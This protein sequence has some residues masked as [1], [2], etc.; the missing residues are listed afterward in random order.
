MREICKENILFLQKKASPHAITAQL[1][2]E[3]FVF[4]K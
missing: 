1:N 2:P 3:F 4:E